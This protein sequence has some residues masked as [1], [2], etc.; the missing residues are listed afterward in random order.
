MALCLGVCGLAAV[1]DREQADVTVACQHLQSFTGRSMMFMLMV[2]FSLPQN[3]LEIGFVCLLT[4][5][6]NF[7][8]SLLL[9]SFILHPKYLMKC[10]LCI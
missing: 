5:F 6:H 3:P 9:G 1:W 10:L 8:L 4:H 2:S 7:A